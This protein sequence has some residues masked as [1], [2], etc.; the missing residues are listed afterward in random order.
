MRIIWALALIPLLVM[1]GAEDEHEAAR[2]KAEQFVKRLYLSQSVEDFCLVR[3]K[4]TYRTTWQE[5]PI[6]V[7]CDTRNRWVALYRE[8]KTH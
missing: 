1:A 5:M 4:D 8:K 3:P 6:T 7:D 2:L